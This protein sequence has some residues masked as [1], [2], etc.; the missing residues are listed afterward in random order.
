VAGLV[1]ASPKAELAPATLRFDGIDVL[2]GVSI[3]VVIL[4]HINI[5][6]A[7]GGHRINSLLPRWLYHLLFTNGD[8]G[9][10]LFFAISGFLIT[11]TSLRRFGSLAAMRPAIF[12]RIRFARIAPLLLL[13]LAVLSVLHLTHV[14]G[15]RISPKIA[16]LPQALFAALTFHINWLE[17]SRHGYLPANWDVLWSLSVEEVFY[18]FFPLLCLLL[19]RFRRGWIAFIAILLMFVAI[20]PYARA[21]LASDNPIWGD[22][23]YLG[24]MDSIALGCLCAMLTNRLLC[25]RAGK[26]QAT[27][28]G[29]LLL[30]IA[31]A[32]ILLWIGLWPRWHWMNFIG[33]T[34]LDGTLLPLGT[35]MILAATVLRGSLGRVWSAPVRWMGRHSYELY[36]THSFFIVTA[37]ELAERWHPT[38][39]RPAAM[40]HPF[41]PGLL[42]ALPPLAALAVETA[43]ILLLSC[44][45]AGLLARCFTEPLNR[46]LR[47][48]APP[49][50]EVPTAR[51][52]VTS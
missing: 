19:F 15:F 39:A 3:L 32:A 43:G 33:R 20:G 8:K 21:V 24:G 42:P 18:L 29:L 51:G 5:H 7:F 2:R 1:E 37:E 4:L 45:L 10:T 49:R 40:P 6:L 36:L 16:T 25:N 30:E 31:G 28:R 41:S 11:L 46:K 12:Y 34:A 23:S 22:S 38:P 13:L 9:V 44:L 17:A 27:R 48:A 35:C 52:A 26:S 47:G 50:H 14:P